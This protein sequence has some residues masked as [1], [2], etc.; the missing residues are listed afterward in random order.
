MA[1]FKDRL[2]E[3]RK[4]R[5]LT[6]SELAELLGKTESVVRKYENGTVYPASGVAIMRY[7]KC[8]REP[9]LGTL[10]GLAKFFDVTTDYLLGLSDERNPVVIEKPLDLSTVPTDDMMRELL[11][12]W[13]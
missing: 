11:R 7:E 10:M 1:E 6:Q 4:E 8:H 12:R 5:E 9:N 13:K 2:K 3:L